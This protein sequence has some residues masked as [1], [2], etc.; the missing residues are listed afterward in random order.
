M[1]ELAASAARE[2]LALFRKH[3]AEGFYRIAALT[4]AHYAEAR[5]WIERLDLPLRTLD[6]LHL[7]VAHGESMLLMTA[8]A[9]LARAARKLGVRTT[10]IS[11]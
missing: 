3:E 2:A 5:G 11:A 1:R 8:D 7:A 10:L 9:L 4:G 6:A